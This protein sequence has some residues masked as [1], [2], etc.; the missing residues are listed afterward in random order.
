MI[1]K[2]VVYRCVEKSAGRRGY[3]RILLEF[4]DQR[5][6]F[7]YEHTYLNTWKI[8]K[9]KY[10]ERKCYRITPKT[11]CIPTR[12]TEKASYLPQVGM[13]S[14]NIILHNLWKMYNEKKSISP[15]GRSGSSIW[16][17]L[18][19]LSNLQQHTDEWIDGYTILRN[20]TLLKIGSFFPSLTPPLPFLGFHSF[21]IN[22]FTSTRHPPFGLQLTSNFFQLKHS[23]RHL[24][25]MN[26]IIFDE[27]HFAM[28]SN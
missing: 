3:S 18:K 26:S 20:I 23:C 24:N 17:I 1:S 2:N 25:R 12:D 13:S 19:T 7:N 14:S 22:F 5:L 16:Y 21:S 15:Q 11:L 27:T 4:L 9:S 28:K 6:L 10:V 8:I